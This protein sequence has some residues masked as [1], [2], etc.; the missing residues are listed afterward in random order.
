MSCLANEMYYE[1]RYEELVEEFQSDGFS[2]E[3]AERLAYC[4]INTEEMREI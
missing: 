1:R 2:Y 3:D 4:K